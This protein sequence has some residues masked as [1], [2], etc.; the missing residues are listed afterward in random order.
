MKTGIVEGEPYSNGLYRVRLQIESRIESV[1]P[2]WL[3]GWLLV[4]EATVTGTR[5]WHT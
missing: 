1:N 5:G 2:G 4:L 3:D